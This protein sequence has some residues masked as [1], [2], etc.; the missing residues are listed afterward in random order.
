MRKKQQLESLQRQVY[1]L[2]NENVQLKVKISS[3]T[4]EMLNLRKMLVMQKEERN[5][6]QTMPMANNDMGMRQVV[7]VPNNTNY[8]G[9][10]YQ[11]VVV[12]PQNHFLSPN[13]YVQNYQQYQQ[14]PFPQVMNSSGIP[15]QQQNFFQFR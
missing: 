1:Q 12:P 15:V 6:H 11:N 4:E 2:N 5:N 14:F 9:M 13:N 7:T 8:D 10:M 3:L